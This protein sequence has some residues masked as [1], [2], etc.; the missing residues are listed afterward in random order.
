MKIAEESMK[1]LKNAIEHDWLSYPVSSLPYPKE[2]IK[3]AIK[4]YIGSRWK[5]L[6][7]FGL[8]LTKLK[9]MSLAEFINDNEAALINTIGK[10]MG[11]M[12]F[13]GNIETIDLPES[14]K[15]TDYMKKFLEIGE[16]IRQ[17]KSTLFKDMQ[18]I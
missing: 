5:T 14:L 13:E 4:Y 3:E 12:R 9:Y 16:K 18:F 6:S 11:S 8:A 17:E 7:G 15:G 10:R 2:K 1:F